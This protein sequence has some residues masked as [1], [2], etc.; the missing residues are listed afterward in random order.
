M[1]KLVPEI[2]YLNF[3]LFTWNFL[4]QLLSNTAQNV[5]M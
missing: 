3:F 1:F 4:L 2:L 5:K